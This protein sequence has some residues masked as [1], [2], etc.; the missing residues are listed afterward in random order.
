MPA[1]TIDEVLARLQEIIDASE[2]SGDRIGYFASLY[3]KVTSQVKEGILHNK[4]ENGPRMASLD[5][6]FANRYLTALEQWKKGQPVTASWKIAFETTRSRQALVLQHL[7]LGINAHINL[8][9]GIAAV[10][11]MQSGQIEDIH[12]D[13]N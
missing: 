3:Y 7:L 12:N 11:T 13:F 5:V 6:T 9:L 10:E 4:F 8:D 2:K 1:N